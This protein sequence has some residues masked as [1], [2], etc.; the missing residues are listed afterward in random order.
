M[1]FDENARM[2]NILFNPKADKI[3]NWVQRAFQTNW[4]AGD[5]VKFPVV[6]LL[7]NCHFENSILYMKKR[8]TKSSNLTINCGQTTVAR[9][10]KRTSLW[11]YFFDQYEDVTTIWKTASNIFWMRIC[12]I[13]EQ[14]EWHDIELHE[15]LAWF[16]YLQHS[17]ITRN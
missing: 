8:Q 9:K 11:F 5:P 6:T 4:L 17:L 13:V 14:I 7:Q 15:S 16:D 1:N 10:I 12:V 2:D 3:L